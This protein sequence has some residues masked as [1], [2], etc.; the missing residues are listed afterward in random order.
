MT[1]AVNVATDCRQQLTPA[2]LVRMGRYQLEQIATDGTDEQK[3]CL[4]DWAY[5]G[6][7]AWFFEHLHFLA[8]GEEWQEA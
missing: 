4:L 6:I 7:P 1:N 5:S 2:A 8:T 3:T